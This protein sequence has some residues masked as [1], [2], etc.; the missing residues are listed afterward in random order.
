[1]EFDIDIFEFGDD[2]RDDMSLDSN[3]VDDE[4]EIESGEVVF[5]KLYFD[6]W[7]YLQKRQGWGIVYD[8]L[9]Q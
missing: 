8:V 5:S 6:I 3:Q 1:M 7:R 2:W 9:V 4:D